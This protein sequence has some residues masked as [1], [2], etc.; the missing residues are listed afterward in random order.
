MKRISHVTEKNLGKCHV[1]KIRKLN[2][3]DSSIYWVIFWNEN[4]LL[5]FQ[6]LEAFCQANPRFKRQDTPEISNEAS[7]DRELI[8]D[9]QDE[10]KTQFLEQNAEKGK[11]EKLFFL[12]Q[13][14][15]V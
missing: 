3:S 1:K 8:L 5:W 7:S 2:I 13:T 4:F 9:I 6:L 10:D 15:S 11:L 14:F 12:N